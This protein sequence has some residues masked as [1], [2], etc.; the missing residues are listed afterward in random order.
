MHRTRGSVRRILAALLTMTAAGA[1]AAPAEAAGWFT[2]EALSAADHIARTP[3]VAVTPNGTR[4]LA[5]EEVPPNSNLPDGIAIRVAGPGGEFGPVQ[6]LPDT[7]AFDESLTVGP[8][9]TAALVWVDFTRAGD[10]LRVARLAPNSTAFAPEQPLA[11]GG[12]VSNAPQTAIAHGDVVI[13]FDTSDQVGEAVVRTVQVFHLP[14]GATT[15]ERV[16]GATTPELDRASFT[17]PPATIVGHPSVAIRGNAVMVAWE[18]EQDGAAGAATSSTLVQ[19]ATW[20]LGSALKFTAPVPITTVTHPGPTAPGVD[21]T[22]AGDGTHVF[23]VW[24]SGENGPLAYADVSAGTPTSVGTIATGAEPADLH[25]RVG[26]GAELL[27]AWDQFIPSE[28]AEGVFASIVPALAPTGTAVRISPLNANRVLGDFEVASDGSAVIVTD[29][30]NADGADAAD[31]QVQAAFRAAGGAFGQIEEVSGPQDHGPNAEFTSASAA[32]SAGGGASV[33]WSA[34]DR[35]PSRNDRIFLSERDAVP[36][37]VSAVALPSSIATGTS[38]RMSATATDNLSPVTIDWDFGDGSRA[39]GAS[40]TH[41]YGAPGTRTV[42]VTAHDRAGNATA[43]T[44]RITV[45]VARD[46][47]LPAITALR[48]T[49]TRFRA[50]TTRTAEFARRR[51]TP[52][53]TTFALSV[54]KRVTIVISL[55]RAGRRPRTLIRSGRGPGAVTLVFSGRVGSDRLD[56]GA[57]TASVVAVDAASHRSRAQRVHFTVVAR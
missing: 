3:M 14:A 56:P 20:A 13:A 9:G 53:G 2:P 11:I 57:Y 44:R 46:R 23:A 55:T 45:L 16:S 38:V 41:A 43:Q 32:V 26:A 24:E 34:V 42:T 6:L 22:L 12:D 30:H 52:V 8:D 21:P 47:T 1:A 10:V 49:H 48:L 5:W 50:G 17:T 27:M 35:P 15:L 28:Q 29:R 40:V 37:T 36:P 19:E 33:A 39:A 54:N 4:I 31:E 51:R 18:R 25:V 7:G